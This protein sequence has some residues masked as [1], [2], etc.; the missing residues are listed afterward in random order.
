MYGQRR[1]LTRS[2]SDP[3]LPS[4]WTRRA[5]SSTISSHPTSDSLQDT[6]PGGLPQSLLNTQPTSTSPIEP[7]ATNL[8]SVSNSTTLKQHGQPP[9]L[10]DGQ[11]TPQRLPQRTAT[12]KDETRACRQ[13]GPAH[14]SRHPKNSS[15]PTAQGTS[16]HSKRS[17]HKFTVPSLSNVYTPHLFEIRLTPVNR[18]VPKH[19]R[20]TASFTNLGGDSIDPS[21]QSTPR[22]FDVRVEI[23]PRKRKLDVKSSH[24]T[25]PQ[26]PKCPSG[27]APPPTS[28]LLGIKSPNTPLSPKADRLASPTMGPPSAHPQQ[29]SELD[30]QATIRIIKSPSSACPEN[31]PFLTEPNETASEESVKIDLSESTDHGE[32]QVIPEPDVPETKVETSVRLEAET[33]GRGAG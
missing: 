20:P 15:D 6:R 21:Q 16:K 29:E 22:S 19:L 2:L 25:K 18:R 28:L 23:P 31:N 12:L 7:S 1:W 4:S 3:T 10:N 17:S 13:A 5:P 32:E 11:L 30:M 8:A 27:N 24:H 9:T 26:E 14:P 33:R